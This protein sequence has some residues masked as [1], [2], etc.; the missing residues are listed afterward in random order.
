MPAD[1]SMLDSPAISM[2]SFYP[3]KVWTPP[4]PGAED[5]T[6]P[7]ADGKTL[8]GRFFPAG[9]GQPTILFFYGNGET[10]P[11]YD[12]IAPLYNRIDVN[13]LVADYRGY[14]RSEGWP[15]F[16]S[17]LSDSKSVLDF[18]SALLAERGYADR[19]FVMGRSMGRHSAFE[20]SANCA[21]RLKGMII[22]SGRPILGNFTY[23]LEPAAAQAL[24]ESYRAKVNSI[25]LPALVIHGEL[26]TLAPVEQ[27]VAMYDGFP[28]PESVF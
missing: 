7:S 23:G 4:P 5:L 22:E 27:A 17:M 24:E 9:T 14:G 12:N 26:D 2:N 21:E 13:F 20:L 15:S 28:N 3:R 6:I 8:S 25:S 10:C 1:F 18:A 16:N 19:V 11:D